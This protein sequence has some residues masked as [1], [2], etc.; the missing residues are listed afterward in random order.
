MSSASQISIVRLEDADFPTA[1]EVMSKSFG[2]DA[3]FINAYF[4]KHDTP[5]G[6]EQGYK[7][8]L[9]WKQASSDSTFLK[10]VKGDV[11]VGIAVWTLMTEPPPQT[12]E[13]VEGKEELPKIW[14]DEK[15]REWMTRLWKS[16]VVPRTKVVNDTGG[17]GVYVLELLAVHPGY[18]RLGAGKALVKWGTDAADRE[19]LKSIVE[20]TLV[21]R[22]LYESCG[23]V[24]HIEEMHF[25]VGEGFE[26]RT[27][28]KLVFLVREP[29]V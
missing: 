24:A 29:Q 27:V 2:S 14:A 5:A 16:Y 15:D 20:G 11:I 26:D 18:Q 1:F 12:L 19:G 21:A 9:A 6:Q 22:R 25:D 7:R 13:E 3:P 8:L 23:L 4:P 17:R 28:P 10:A